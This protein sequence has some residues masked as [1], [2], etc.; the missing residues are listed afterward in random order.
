MSDNRDEAT[1][2][3]APAET[4][5]YGKEQLEHEAGYIPFKDETASDED[6]TYD[7]PSEAADDYVSRTPESEIKTYSAVDLPENVTL[8]LEQAAKLTA[9]AKDAEREQAEKEQADLL[10]EEVQKIRGE[11]AKPE[12][13]FDVA[14]ALERPEFKEAFEARTAEIE[15]TRAE[16]ETHK[17][18]FE[19]A[20]DVAYRVAVASVMELFPEVL[21]LPVEHQTPALAQLVQE[22]PQ[23]A[24]LLHRVLT[25]ASQMHEIQQNQQARKSE[26]EREKFASYAKEQNEVFAERTKSIPAAQMRAIEAEVPK[27]L[28]EYGASPA[29]FLQAIGDST[30]FP[31]AAAEMIMVDAARY[32]LMLQAPKAI[33]SRGIPPVQRPGTTAPRGSESRAD[34]AALERQFNEATGDKQV[35]LAAKI[36]SLKKG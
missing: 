20:S 22:D 27:M 1:G 25:R 6:K 17:Q 16:A 15:K 34:I 31:R 33:A 3:F 21:S 35:R 23:R 28:Q 18:A 30:D 9:D 7:T 12:E 11:D 5:L 29:Q 19:V 24:Q 2:Q 26:T 13:P 4:P 14:K 36:R 32:R 8:T 10:R